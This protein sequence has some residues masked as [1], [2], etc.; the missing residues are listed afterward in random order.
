MTSHERPGISFRAEFRQAGM[1]AMGETPHAGSTAGELLPPGRFEKACWETRGGL[2]AAVDAFDQLAL[3]DL[4]G[5]LIC[6]F[7]FYHDK[8]A[9]C[10]P[11]GVRYGAQSF[12]TGPPTPGALKRIGRALLEACESGGRRGP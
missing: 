12:L 5:S 11:D 8:W 1:S 4:K 9:V 7:F 10:T 3:F 6:Q 2:I